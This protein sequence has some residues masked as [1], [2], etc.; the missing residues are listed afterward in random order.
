VCSTGSV[1]CGFLLGMEDHKLYRSWDP[2]QCLLL[3]PSLLDWLPEGDLA[4]FIL[5]VVGTLDLRAIEDVYQAKD[6]RGTRPYSPRMLTALLIYGYCVG[7][8][9]SR[10]IEAATWRDVAFRVLAADQHPDH[11]VLSEF[12]RIHLDALASL[13]LATVRL[14]QR[15]G[16]VQL[17][18][19][20]LDG[21]KLK[22]NASKH[23]AMSYGRMLKTESELRSE[24]ER[25]LRE[26]EQADTAEDRRYGAARG[27]ELPEEV[28]R[29]SERLQR[30]EAARAAL[31]AEARQVRVQELEEQAQR[32]EKHAR[33]TAD[34]VEGKR[35]RTR[36]AKAREQAERLRGD[37]ET[38]AAPGSSGDPVPHH[39]VPTTP[40]GLPSPQ[41]QRNFT[42]PDSRIMKRDGTYLQ[43][44]NGQIAVDSAHQVIVACVVTNQPPDQE[45]LVPMVE[46]VCANCGADPEKLLADAG[47]WGQDNVS[48]C[49]ARGVDPYLAP[50]KQKHGEAETLQ[51]EGQWDGADARARMAKK[52]RS[53]EGRAVYARR[54]TIVE[55]VF[56]Q[57][58][59]A[60]GIRNFLLRGRRKVRGEWGLICAAHNLLKVF[61]APVVIPA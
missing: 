50:S 29:R 44:Y 51:G 3:P 15:A 40:A 35:A 60:Q 61:R 20:A 4:Y 25:M 21:T 33:D 45:H 27:D 48:F 23:K 10:R 16:L 31:E 6:A 32:Q 52:L 41:A 14:A 46:Q 37:D 24:I 55:P 22:A 26:A 13:F 9:S 30:I 12:R 28:R 56:G 17:G 54:K 2:R 53:P 58:R 38:P 36:A 18:Q 57:I 42:D 1:S 39:R 49:E 59:E 34:P 7:I 11:T 19:V 8:R 5:D 47:Y 43:G